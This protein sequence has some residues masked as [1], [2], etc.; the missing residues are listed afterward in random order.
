MYWP[1][2]CGWHNILGQSTFSVWILSIRQLPRGNTLECTGHG[3]VN[4]SDMWRQGCFWWILIGQYTDL[5]WLT[6][7]SKHDGLQDM[8]DC[9]HLI[10]DCQRQPW[11]AW[12]M[13]TKN[14]ARKPK[15]TSCCWLLGSTVHPYSSSCLSYFWACFWGT[16]EGYESTHML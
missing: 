3:L 8:M 13:G 12:Q 4:P 11:K 2:L 10:F 7:K 14:S 15:I 16:R 9:K 1:K 5:M 6:Y